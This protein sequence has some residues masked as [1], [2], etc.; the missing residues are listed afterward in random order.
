MTSMY[1]CLNHGFTMNVL[2]HYLCIVTL[3]SVK[4]KKKKIIISIETEK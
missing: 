1:N 4:K 2:I 3:Y